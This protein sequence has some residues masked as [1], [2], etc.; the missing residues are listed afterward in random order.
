MAQVCLVG[1][2]LSLSV[3]IT[4]PLYF[5]GPN[6]PRLVRSRV[7][8]RPLAGS[9]PGGRTMR[10]SSRSFYSPLIDPAVSYG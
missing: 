8:E 10:A 3:F 9:I 7:W 1:L 5:R 4:K 2:V 6:L